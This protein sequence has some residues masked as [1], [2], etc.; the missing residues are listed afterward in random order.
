[1]MCGNRKSTPDCKP[2]PRP[3]EESTPSPTHH[4]TYSTANSMRLTTAE[5]GPGIYSKMI[6]Q[7]HT[8]AVRRE[9]GKGEGDMWGRNIT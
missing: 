7:P 2:L 6:L 5:C 9:E 8:T 1:M 3:M 4:T